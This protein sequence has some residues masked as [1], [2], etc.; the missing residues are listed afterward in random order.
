MRWKLIFDV[1]AY[2]KAAAGEI[3]FGHWDNYI[4]NKTTSTSMNAPRTDD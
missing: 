2:L 4:G 3:L 1:D